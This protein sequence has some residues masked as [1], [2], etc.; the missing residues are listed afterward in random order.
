MTP[1]PLTRRPVL[2]APIFT[3]AAL[4]APLAFAQPLL[5]A[6][7]VLT[8]AAAVF[9]DSLRAGTGSFASLSLLT[10]TNDPLVLRYNKGDLHP[11]L[12]TKWEQID[13]VTMR[14][15]RSEE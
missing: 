3:L 11:G 1:R 7:K 12:A 6:D 8:V 4:L 13:P 10:Q 2:A 15:H 5:A 14:F 9:P